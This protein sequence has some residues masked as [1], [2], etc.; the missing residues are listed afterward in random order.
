M[1]LSLDEPD[2]FSTSFVYVSMKLSLLIIDDDKHFAAAMVDLLESE[3]HDVHHAKTFA[4]GLAVLRRTQCDAVLLDVDL[5]DIRPKKG[6]DMLPELRKVQQGIT[7]IV[8]T[9]YPAVKDGVFAVKN[10]AYDYFSKTEAE[11]RIIPML[12]RVGERAGFQRTIKS[13]QDQV[14]TKDP[15]VRIVG[16]ASSIRSAKDFA[17]KAAQTD[18]SV[19]LLGETGTGKDLFANAIH[20][21]SLRKNKPFV[22]LNCSAIPAELIE[23]ELFGYVKGAFSG[24]MNEKRGLMEEAHTGTLFLDEIG[25]MPLLLQAK[26]LR[27]L[28]TKTLTKLGATKPVPCDF[29]VIAATHHNLDEESRRG[30]F[31]MDLYQRLNSF[32]IMIPAL[33]DRAEDVEM[34]LQYFV[35]L[36]SAQYQ[37]MI[38][39]F[40]DM[41]KQALLRYEWAGNIREVR[42]TVERCV[43]LCEGDTMTQD[44]L[45]SDVFGP[46]LIQIEK[47]MSTT[48]KLPSKV[49]G[50]SSVKEQ[51]KEVPTKASIKKKSR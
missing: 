49:T 51:I 29:R 27:V 5:P 33:R 40:D 34:L 23:S 41:T 47:E 43:I 36:F 6:V 30:V 9:A 8:M 42:N 14:Q 50:K 24:A 26:L 3:D 46:I 1:V 19:L 15:F 16:N 38:V 10:G 28:E 35:A 44:V 11:D 13:L 37:K 48:K 7:V 12:E 17:R 39:G 18:I 32:R 45:P 25:D 21:A 22:A 20:Q 4:D 2:H 31:R